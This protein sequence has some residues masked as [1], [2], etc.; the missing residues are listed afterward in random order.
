MCVNEY[1]YFIYRSTEEIFSMF[2]TFAFTSD[3]IK[4]AVK[5]NFLFFEDAKEDGFSTLFTSVTCSITFLT[6]HRAI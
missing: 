3:A 4:D 1:S 6:V 5:G 2:I